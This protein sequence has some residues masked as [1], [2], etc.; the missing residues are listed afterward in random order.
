M[1]HG[2][3]L[4]NLEDMEALRVILLNR[5]VR[6]GLI[7]EVR[8]KHLHLTEGVSQADIQGKSVSGSRNRGAKAQGTGE[9]LGASEHL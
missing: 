3:W 8:L 6:V 1:G 9:H 2:T 4:G 5:V 7:G